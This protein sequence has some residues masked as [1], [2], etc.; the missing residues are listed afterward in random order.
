MGVQ[1]IRKE[2]FCR[3]L[4]VIV[5]CALVFLFAYNSKTAGYGT[6]KARIT[7]VTASKLWVSSQKMEPAPQS[8]AVAFPCA[9]VLC[10]FA[11]RLPRKPLLRRAAETP[12]LALLPFIEVQRFLRPPPVVG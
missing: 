6:S 8:T 7:P 3:T 4:I 2:T 11:L 5:V 12:A 1:S 10:F 9:A